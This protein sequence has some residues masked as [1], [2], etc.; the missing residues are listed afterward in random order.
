MQEW[1]KEA[2][3]DKKILEKTYDTDVHIKAVSNAQELTDAWNSMG[4]ENNQ[5]VT[6]DTVIINT[7][8][9]KTSLG[10]GNGNWVESEDISKLDNKHME[11]L[12]LYG[13]NAGHLDNAKENP[14]AQFSKKTYNSPVIASDGTVYGRFIFGNYFSMNNKS[15]KNQSITNRK[16]NKGWTI[17][18]S[19]N[20]GVP[21]V[22]KSYKRLMSLNKMINAL[23]SSNFYSVK[24]KNK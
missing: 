18:R 22:I 14:A 23:N 1:E 16:K 9:N 4:K 24:N 21:Q 8:A 20:I 13:C 10:F 3:A 11:N 19:N 12:I 7:H 17:Y 15:F 2:L 6:I 5:S